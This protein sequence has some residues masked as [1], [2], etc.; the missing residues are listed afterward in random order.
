MPETI[1]KPQT[2]TP[3]TE[4]TPTT[5]PV[6]NST[7]VTE[8]VQKLTDV[9]NTIKE[10]DVDTLIPSDPYYMDPL[11]YE[12]ANFFGIQQEDYDAAKTKLADIVDFVIRDIKDNAPD[13]V[14]LRLREIERTLQPPSWD[15][16]RYTNIHKYIRLAS[17]RGAL[18]QAMKAFQKDEPKGVINGQ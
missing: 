6:V 10:V 1:V 4:A 9:D 11:F 7:P 5:E 8:Q 3:Q 14:L 13:K 17:K 12:V 16:R 2:G 18:D 15:E